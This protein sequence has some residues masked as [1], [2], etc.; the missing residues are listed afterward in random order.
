VTK[1]HEHH[2]TVEGLKGD[3]DPADKIEDFTK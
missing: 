2:R 1:F 3:E